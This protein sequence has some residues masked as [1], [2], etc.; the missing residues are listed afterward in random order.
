MSDRDTKVTERAC[1]HNRT[2]SDVYS[3]DK[4]SKAVDA[5]TSTER[6]EDDCFKKEEDLRLSYAAE[7]RGIRLTIMSRRLS[8][9]KLNTTVMRAT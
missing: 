6:I 8:Q 1:S 5:S 2:M 7:D 3:L 9:Q 4:T